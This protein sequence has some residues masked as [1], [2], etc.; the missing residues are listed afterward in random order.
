ML[1]RLFR[2]L[3][4]SCGVVFRTIRAF[5]TRQIYAVVARAKSVTS[6]T[7]QA[8]KLAPAM[9]KTATEAGK[10]PTKREDY[11]E[12]KQLFI[13]KS[14]LIMVPLILVVLAVLIYFV[15]WPWL[16][17][18]FFTAKMWYEDPDTADYTGKVILYYEKKK[19]TVMFE[20]RLEE[21]VIQGTGRS[22]DENGLLLYSGDYVDGVYSGKGSLYDAGAL[23]YEG[24]FEDGVFCG[25]GS[26]YQD[27]VLI[28]RGE[29]SNGVYDGTG[30]LYEEDG[31][32]LYAG[33]FSAG[34][35]SGT[36]TAYAEG[37]RCYKGEFS[38]DL[39]NGEGIQYDAD[40][41]IRYRGSFLDGLYCGTG[42]LNLGN[43]GTVQ[44]EFENGDVVGTAQCFL[45]GKLYYEG[46]LE[47]LVPDGIGTLYAVSGAELF[48]GPMKDG[49]I[50]GGALLGISAA[51]LREML[52]GDTTECSYEQG[53]SITSGE[54]GFTAFCSYAQQ[55]ADPAVY[56]VFLYSPGDNSPLG[57]LLWDTAAEFEA[58]TQTDEV[59]PEQQQG[60]TAAPAFPAA[61]PVDL[62]ME[63]Y[64]QPYLYDGYTLN[65]WSA[66]RA[67]ELLLLEWHLGEELPEVASDAATSSD[68]TGRLSA[69]IDKL[70]L[71]AEQTGG[72]G[73]QAG[74]SLG[75]DAQEILQAAADRDENVYPVLTALLTY[76]ENKEQ[77][78]AAQENLSLYQTLADEE[79]AL[80]N[81]GKG[82]AQQLA[83]L[84][85]AVA[86]LNVQIAKYT[87]QMRKEAR[88]VED[89]SGL[90]VTEYDL[91][92]LLLLFDVSKLD[93]DALG[94]AV[95][96]TAQEAAQEAARKDKEAQETG[97]D[98]G[99]PQA[100]DEASEGDEAE[101][102][103]EVLGLQEA[104][105]EPV[106]TK[107]LLEKLEDSVLELELAY[108][109]VLLA[110]RQYES[111]ASYV[112]ELNRKYTVGEV[113]RS[114]LLPAQITMNSQRGALYAA[115]AE[116]SRQA[117]LLDEQSGGW[118]SSE[119]DWLT[120]VLAK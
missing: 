29:F 54:L 104:V 119:Y 21:G 57:E 47:Q 103:K 8:S 74:Q 19:K 46:T 33:E 31:R 69:L 60:G 20:G 90:D 84:E 109:D 34:L 59:R 22:F 42:T 52:M 100:S 50:D 92:G 106:D 7:R 40:G 66:G 23:I 51:D 45:G 15:V 101:R 117:A 63:S 16:L 77:C 68:S 86:E 94:S 43:G 25:T 62:G 6:L 87:V 72:A 83:R 116:F 75:K 53:F 27:D 97:S 99:E 11:I 30:T 37:K 108:Q 32:L 12:T 114:E 13:S 107:R 80:L 44:A 111:A 14:L 115:L 89:A 2:Q 58:L 26:L 88:T 65:L 70:G 73:G 76:L 17:S 49:I 110:L 38:D 61:L 67:G 81:K 39:Y 85:D 9:L 18:H 64:C 28:Y 3:T 1:S 5:F 93:T 55:D 71:I 36:G 56:Y 35:R 10:K 112:E 24:K 113:S 91:S 79:S 102:Y 48:S 120:D 78:T 105:A 4:A 95:I 98:S 41:S 96:K 118:L 82:D